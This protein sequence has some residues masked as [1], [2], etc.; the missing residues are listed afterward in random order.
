MVVTILVVLLL[1]LALQL[2]VYGNGGHRAISDSPGCSSIGAWAGSLPYLQRPVEYP[3]L[4]GG[5]L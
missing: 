1:G 4:A 5:L 3:V 2:V